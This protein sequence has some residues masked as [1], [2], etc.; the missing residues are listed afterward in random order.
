[1]KKKVLIITWLSVAVAFV[2]FNVY[3]I[4]I[5]PPAWWRFERQ[6]DKRVIL[7]YVKSNYPDAKKTGG[8]FPV[9]K[10]AQ[11][12]SASTMYFT[13]DD[14]DFSVSAE[15]GKVVRDNYSRDRATAQ[16]DKIIQDGFLKPRGIEATGAAYRFSDD[17]VKIYPYN[18]GLSVTLSVLDQGSTPEEIIWLYDF[19]MYWKEEGAF[20][21][22]YTVC[23]R[24]VEKGET[25]YHIYYDD[26][27]NFSD[28][29]EF[30]AAFKI[31]PS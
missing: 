25:L 29:S 5:D 30:Y 23:I 2:L 4:F 10:I 9:P 11:S 31:G 6:R 26:T 20:L 24:I 14:V 28:E 19:Y 15:Y 17:Y 18:G 12:H 21:T 27:D 13:L 1:M 3:D 8:L 22:E 7:D 16:F